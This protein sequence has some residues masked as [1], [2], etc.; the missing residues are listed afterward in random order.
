MGGGGG[1]A[2]VCKC[3][4]LSV[5][6]CG[7]RTHCAHGLVHCVCASV[8]VSLRGLWA[9]VSVSSCAGVGGYVRAC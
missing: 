5:R 7:G 6:V 8:S 1:G 4:S 2:H 9:C 3:P